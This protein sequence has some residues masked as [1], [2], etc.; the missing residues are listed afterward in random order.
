MDETPN[1]DLQPLNVPLSEGNGM[2]NDVFT[3]V[4]LWCFLCREA[5]LAESWSQCSR[6]GP[7]KIWKEQGREGGTLWL[8]TFNLLG[9]TSSG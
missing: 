7:L 8:G 9:T 2:R 1:V 5:V 4:L 3:S 6:D